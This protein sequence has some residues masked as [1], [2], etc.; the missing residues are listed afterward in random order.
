MSEQRTQGW[1]QERV[2]RV[3]GSEIHKVL[4]KNKDGRPSA[5]R[6]SYK[7]QKVAER[8]CGRPCERGYTNFSMQQG[9]E[10]EPVARAEY[11]LRTLD[12]VVECGFIV[13]PRI[14]LAGASPDGLISQT[15]VL[16]I[17]CCEHAAHL[18][19]LNGNVS[20]EYTCQ[21]QW[22][23]ATTERAWCDLVFYNPDFADDEECMHVIRIDRDERR[24]AELEREVLAFL[25]EV[26]EEVDA[27]DRRRM[28]RQAAE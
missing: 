24:I 4:A 19:A 23:L 28:M 27:L 9:I 25:A 1:F 20:H 6:N 14:P 18:A 7:A 8:R 15:G 11:A 12:E 5:I 26:Q 22:E 2:G 21:V 13:H 10:R 17:K 3:T 16:E